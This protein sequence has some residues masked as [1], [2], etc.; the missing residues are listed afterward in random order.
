MHPP[1]HDNMLFLFLKFKILKIFLTQI[2]DYFY[3]Q[4]REIYYRTNSFKGWTN[5]LSTTQL[6]TLL[7]PPPLNYEKTKVIK[8]EEYLTDKDFENL[9]RLIRGTDSKI[10]NSESLINTLE[11]TKEFNYSGNTISKPF[12]IDNKAIIFR[13]YYDGSEV[14]IFLEKQI[15]KWKE[16][17][18]KW[19]YSPP[20]SDYTINYYTERN[21]KIKDS[22]SKIKPL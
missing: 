11:L 1:Y 13:T 5:F 17:C 9:R 6:N 16:V 20:S 12:I 19:I 15:D 4:P 8:W 10:L 3:N 14:I 22:I 7:G 2:R 21:K 18:K